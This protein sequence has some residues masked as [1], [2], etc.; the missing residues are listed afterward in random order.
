MSVPPLKVH[1]TVA[2]HHTIHNDFIASGGYRGS[3]YLK[4]QVCL[5]GPEA[6]RI[7]FGDCDARGDMRMI[8]ELCTRYFIA[9][10]D[11]ERLRPSVHALLTKHWRSV[12]VVAEALL[13][14][15]TLAG[16]EIDALCAAAVNCLSL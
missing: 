14:R 9:D 7:A 13:S 6:E 8:E 15:R 4:I 11:V 3:V 12:E 1:A 5:A 2:G 10:A 16:S